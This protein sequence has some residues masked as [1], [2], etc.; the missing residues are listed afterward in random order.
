[1]EGAAKIY[2]AKCP[3]FL[4][5]EFRMLIVTIKR[6]HHIESRLFTLV[7]DSQFCEVNSCFTSKDVDTFAGQHRKAAMTLP[8]LST[9]KKGSERKTT[10]KST[11]HFLNEAKESASQIWDP[12]HELLP[13]ISALSE[14]AKE[15]EAGKKFASGT[16]QVLDFGG[17]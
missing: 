12:A 10:R 1:M 7:T 16:Q 3:S 9:K 2:H 11:A 15:A 5:R 13:E 6:L 4:K 17:Q 14:R 8:Y